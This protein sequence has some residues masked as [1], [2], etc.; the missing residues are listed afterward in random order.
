[1]TQ[2]NRPTH[3][4]SVIL[5]IKNYNRGIKNTNS[6]YFSNHTPNGEQPVFVLVYKK[7]P[8]L[9]SFFLFVMHVWLLPA[10]FLFAFHRPRFVCLYSTDSTTETNL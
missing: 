8:L 7:Y 5:I 2:T 6:K 3:P 1:M 10:I 9:D 4:T